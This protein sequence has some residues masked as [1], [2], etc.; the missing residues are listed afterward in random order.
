M[1]GEGDVTSGGIRVAARSA[2]RAD[3]SIDVVADERAVEALAPNGAKA[4]EE[5]LGAVARRFIETHELLGL[6]V[7]G[8]RLITI[9]EKKPDGAQVL[10]Q[11]DD[12]L[13]NR[14]Q[15]DGDSPAERQRVQLWMCGESEACQC[16][17][18]IPISV[19]L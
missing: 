4:D 12:Q 13:S 9:A 16:C 8:L 11:L 1:T 18:C 6:D 19:R 5:W 10:F 7:E 2:I 3:V 17:Y 14:L 15:P